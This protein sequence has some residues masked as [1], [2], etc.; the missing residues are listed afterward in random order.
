MKYSGQSSHGHA[1]DAE[2]DPGWMNDNSGWTND[3]SGWTNNHSGWTNND[4][5]W[6]NEVDEKDTTICYSYLDISI[7]VF[8]CCDNN[9]KQLMTSKLDKS[10]LSAP[11][12]LPDTNNKGG[13]SVQLPVL[14]GISE[15]DGYD[16]PIPIVSFVRANGDPILKTKILNILFSYDLYK[17]FF[18][19][20][21]G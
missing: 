17:P 4:S 12:I 5:G 15:T 7:I 6:T 21:L 18:D 2:D 1:E 11:L 3:D 10:Q 14:R 20:S 8:L 16:T 19:R 13:I 9:C